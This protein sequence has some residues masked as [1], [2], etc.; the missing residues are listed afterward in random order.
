MY[1]LMTDASPLTCFTSIYTF[2][3]LKKKKGVWGGGASS[4]GTSKT[5]NLNLPSRDAT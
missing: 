2:H 5:R 1:E 4:M 3:L